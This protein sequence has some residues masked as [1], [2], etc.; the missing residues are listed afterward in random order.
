MAEKPKR[1]SAV[2]V[3]RPKRGGPYADTA[4]QSLNHVRLNIQLT[5]PGMLDTDEPFR[6]QI[7]GYLFKHYRGDVLDGLQAD[8]RRLDGGRN[9]R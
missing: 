5:V 8:R 6:R 2:K 4:E 7:I 1:K 3:S 9:A